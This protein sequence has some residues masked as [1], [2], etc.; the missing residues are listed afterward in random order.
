MPLGQSSA[1]DRH[2]SRH[3]GGRRLHGL[4]ARIVRD[5][6]LAP[7][8][9]GRDHV[10]FLRRVSARLVWSSR[11]WSEGREFRGDVTV[12]DLPGHE[13]PGDG[14]LRDAQQPVTRRHHDVGDR[15][16]RPITGR[17]SGRS[18]R[19]PA[20]SSR[21]S[22]GVPPSRNRSAEPLIATI[23][24]GSIRS[25]IP[26]NSIVPARR[27][28]SPAGVTATLASWKESGRSGDRCGRTVKL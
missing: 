28:R 26:L 22:C 13:L 6:R 27:I 10:D 25:L 15:R 24:R 17:P 18:G 3:P 1:D 5:R 11:R 16:R 21:R 23:R 14:T 19:I 2:Q 12:R 20:H 4:G 8:R 7:R 9:R